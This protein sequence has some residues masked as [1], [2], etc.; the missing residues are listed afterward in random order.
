MRITTALHSFDPWPGEIIENKSKIINKI[1]EYRHKADILVFPEMSLPGYCIGDLHKDS[2]FINLQEHAL[3][4]IIDASK[5]ITVII[6]LT[7]LDHSGK[8]MS[9]GTVARY[10]GFAVI[11]DGQL[12]RMGKKT[13]LVDEGVLEDSRY[14]LLGKKEEIEPVEVFVKGQKIVLGIMVCQDMWDDYSE[15]KVAD[16][17]AKKGADFLV[18]LNS[19][20]FYVGKL[21]KRIQTALARVSETSLPLLYVNTTGI[22]DI[23]KNIV[24]FDGRSFAVTQSGVTVQEGFLTETLI[25]TFD[26]NEKITELPYWKAEKDG[27]AVLADSLIYTLREFFR[28]TKVFKRAVIGLSGGIDSALDALLITKALGSN[29]LIC[30]NMPSRFNSDITR[31]IAGKIAAA[32]DAEYYIHPIQEIVDLKKKLL[33]QSLGTVSGLTIENL[34][35]RARGSIL[36]EYSQ[37][38]AAMV[39]GNG[40]KTEFQ[41]GYA[42][43]YGDIL[44][45][46]MPLGDVN[47]LLV[48]ALAAHLDPENRILPRELFEIVPSAELSEAHNIA[49]GKGDPFDYYVESPIGVEIVENARSPELLKKLFIEQGLDSGLWIPDRQ[50]RTVYEKFSPESFYIYAQSVVRAIR[51]SYF[52][53]VQAPPIPVVSPRAF[54]MDYRE[55]LFLP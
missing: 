12:I 33:E 7:I 8:K 19:S 54:G 42:T 47:K 51:K 43:L 38:K 52:K 29:S 17:L 20:P 4:E 48:F 53:R 50:G 27:I 26:T 16:I 18:V 5:G 1:D 3:K 2:E 41:R 24:I 13:L 14:F 44:G 35:A 30:V 32:L 21:E 15:V 34:Q 9:D 55:S 40:N 25:T 36:M 37:E 23:G 11:S 31:N 49:Q 39:I 10:N 28:R 46:I 45:A 6:G 22:Q